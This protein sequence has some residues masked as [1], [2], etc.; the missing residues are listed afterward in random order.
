MAS[1]FP[2]MDP[3]LEDPAFWADFHMTFIG[4][5]R[6]AVAAALPDNYDARLDET[7]NLVQM[8]PAVIKLI[9]P[10][11]AVS[12]EPH[13]TKRTSSRSAGTQLLEPVSIPHEFLEEVRQTRIEILHRPER[14]LVAVLELLSPFNKSGEGF[15]QYRAKRKTI[16]LQKLHLVELD[17]LVGGKRLP[18]SKPLPSADHY[19]LISPAD[20]RP[21]CAVYHWALR[22]PL[23]TIP[24]PLR[25]PD[26][27][28]PIDLGKVFRDTY[29]RGR[30]ARSLFYTQPPAAR[31]SR[32]DVQWATGVASKKTR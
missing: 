17:L 30:Y 22:D 4:C 32:K 8:S 23:P 26:A 29:E 11:V 24:I 7:V 21:H 28:I 10:D 31:L 14:T 27:D 19:A 12:R 15:D 20:D 2:G 9:Y 25:A 3:Y 6:E 18:L 16:L 1:P 13:R 5:W